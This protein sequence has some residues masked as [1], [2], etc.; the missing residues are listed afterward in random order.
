MTEIPTYRELEQKIKWI[1]KS[2]TRR[3]NSLIKINEELEREIREYACNDANELEIVSQR[4]VERTKELKC[5]Y[6]ISRYRASSDYSLD[7]IL[8]TVIDFIP[9]AFQY[10]EV[11]CVR[12]VFDRYEFTTVKCIDTK[13]K[14][15]QE[16]TVNNKKIGTLEVCFLK[17]PETLD[18]GPLYNEAIIFIRTIAEIIAKIVE[19][20][21]AEEEIRKHRDQIKKLMNSFVQ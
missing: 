5:L 11:T 20:E 10:P 12:A 16:I 6:D 2:H 14:L 7:T 9:P 4:L 17:K 3:T 19:R 15:V 18:K 21:W 8:Q 1:E 13:W